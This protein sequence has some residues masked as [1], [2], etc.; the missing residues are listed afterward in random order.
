M[1]KVSPVSIKYIIYADFIANGVVEKPDVIGALF[2]QTEGL[3]G[4]DLEL[5]ELQR[6]G[7]IGR[8]EVQLKV[9]GGKTYGTIIIPTSLDKV[10]TALIAAMIETVDRVGPTTAKIKVRKI[11]DVRQAK[12]IYIFERA[13]ELLKNLIEKELPDTKEIVQRLEESLRMLEITEYGPEKLPAG[14]AIDE[15]DEIIIVEGRADVLNLLKHGFKNVIA[16]NGSR[17]PK[18]IIDLSKKKTTIVFVDG[19]RGGDLIVKQ[20]MLAGVDIDYVAKAPPGREVEELT[21]KEIIKALRNKVP[22]DQVKQYYEKLEGVIERKEERKLYDLNEEQIKK[23]REYLDKIFATRAALLLDKD[24][25]V[26]NKVPVV[27]LA[28]ALEKAN[29]VY[30]VVLDSVITKDLVTLAEKKGIELLV[31]M[32]SGVRPEETKVKILTLKQLESK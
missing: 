17:V 13:K 3:L 30:A 24:L 15:S 16:L 10:E 18:A 11:E 14:P 32:D 19:D 9:E 25:N 8:I 4:P 21:K 23:L 7:K 5:R 28:E 6:S 29:N 31:G 22:F 2:G 12:R 26:I 20:L 1:A 27:K